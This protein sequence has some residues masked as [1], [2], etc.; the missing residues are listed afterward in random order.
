[1]SRV[2]YRVVYHVSG[3]RHYTLT[4]HVTL[5]AAN[6]EAHTLNERRLQAH[7]EIVQVRL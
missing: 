5:R 2:V 1:M 6:T 7:V 3:E 4:D